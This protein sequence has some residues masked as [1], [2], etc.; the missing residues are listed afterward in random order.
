MLNLTDLNDEFA[1]PAETDRPS[2]GSAI[3]NKIASFCAQAGQAI[4][5]SRQKQANCHLRDYFARQSDE[6]LIRLRMSPSEIA[7]VRAG[8]W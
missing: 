8:K 4:Y 1:S 5:V 2:W 3:A 6:H 7:S